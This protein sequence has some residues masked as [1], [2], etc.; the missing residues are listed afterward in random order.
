MNATKSENPVKTLVI[1]LNMGGPQNKDEVH[2]YL[3]EL[4][5]DREILKLPFQK[6][7]GRYIAWRRTPN[8]QER[9][10]EIGQYSPTKGIMDDQSAEIAQK[11]DQI[12]PQSAP[13]VCVSGFRYCSPRTS[14]MIEQYN[15]AEKI[16]LFSQYP[17]HS[18]STSGSSFC[19]AY[20]WLDK[21]KDEVYR[22]RISVIDQW[23]DRSDYTELWAMLVKRKFDEMK[24]S[25]GLKDKDIRIIYS[26][27]SLPESYCTE[28]GDKYN[29]EI[30]GS[31]ERIEK[32]LQS[33]GLEHEGALAWQ[34]KVGPQRT[35]WLT[36]STPEVI[37]ETTQ[38]AILMV[39]IAFTTDHIETLDEIDIEFRGYAEEV[40]DHFARVDCFNLEEKFIDLCTRLII[41]HIEKG[42]H[43]AIRPCC[44]N[45]EGN[46][47]AAMRQYFGSKPVSQREL[48]ENSPAE[49]VSV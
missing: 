38:K 27:H 26:A 4:F 14:E 47:C 41:E 49:A 35:K 44:L 31:F 2:P 24:S 10:E 16:I 20:R 17:Q 21:Q 7:L 18:C 1:L 6:V 25:T 22:D 45:C 23:W 34:S 39:P 29:E 13:H 28:K 5:Q 36:P 30:R 37:A 11:L 19:D 42:Y 8:I 3:K 46:D 40:V 48:L 15:S 9:Y 12:H 32:V 33:L 43:S